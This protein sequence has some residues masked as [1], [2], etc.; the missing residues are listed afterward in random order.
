MR[1]SKI[2]ISSA[3]SARATNFEWR[4]DL[5]NYRHFFIIDFAAGF[6]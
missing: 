6:A 5:R 1:C 3:F 2:K 4:M